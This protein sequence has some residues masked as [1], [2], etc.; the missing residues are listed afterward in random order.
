[1]QHIA[2]NLPEA[3]TDYKGVTKSSYPTRN[4][5]ERVEGPNKNIQLLPLPKKKGRSM[6]APKNDAQM[7]RQRIPRTKSTKSVNPNQPKVGRR[8]KVD[9]NPIP[10]PNPQPGSMVHRNTDPGRSE[11]PDS[12]VLGNDESDQ[13]VKEIFVNY[14]DSGESYNRKTTIVNIYFSAA[15][16]E[17]FLNDPDPKTMAECKKC[18]D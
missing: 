13:G 3:F 18:S 8:P 17:I 14:I 6:A 2:N 1:L 4:A 15:I 16:A 5:P 10:G 12:T 11:H 9:T 7:K